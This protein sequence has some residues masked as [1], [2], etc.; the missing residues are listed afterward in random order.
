MPDLDRLFHPRSVAVVGISNN[1]HKWGGGN[2]IETLLELGFEGK[3]YPVSS[4]MSEFKGLRVYPS[5]EDV[6]DSIDLVLISIPAQSTPQLMEECARKGVSFAQLYAA[7][8]SEV[9]GEGSSL[10]TKVVE[11]AARGGVRVVGPNCMG[12]YCPSGRFSWRLDFP[13][14]S[15]AVAFLSQSGLNAVQ[16]ATLGAAREVRFSKVISYGNAADLNEADFL[17]YFA[18]DLESRVV[19]AY[20]EGVKDG[21]R[22]IAALRKAAQVKP[23]IVLKGGRSQAGA[24]ATVSHTAALAGTS[25]VWAS[26]LRQAGAIE[27]R[28]FDE[29]LDATLA[30]LCLPAPEHSGVALIGTG[31]GPG[32]VG[33][34]ECEDAGLIVP[35]LPGEAVEALRRFIPQEGTSL[36]NPVDS[37]F[38]FGQTRQQ[39]QETIAIVA[40]CP[41]IACLIIH[42]E[43]DT[44]L[45]FLGERE[46]ANTTEAITGA[47]RDCAKLV[48]VVLRTSG[49]P[50][51]V[52][53]IL[54]QQQVLVEAGIP[55]Y[56]TMRRAAQAIGKVIQ[57]QRSRP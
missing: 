27:V 10:E 32:V 2:W 8:F 13:R 41:E 44:L 35:P 51:A 6:P 56:P 29:L 49:F 17:E 34:D 12:V 3:I 31:G 57:Y 9:G 30:F 43:I 39:L 38:G 47:A 42:I 14:E 15:G 25:T 33:A 50:E 5:I 26:V 21:Q 22:F 53:T 18:A 45:H 52:K 19:T 48:T 7:G 11:I 20:I 1:P 54:E 46:L 4:T 24:R 23:V 40:S 16:V 55:V 36:Q 28:S 37:P